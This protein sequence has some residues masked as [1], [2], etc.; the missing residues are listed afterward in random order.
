MSG[1]IKMKSI[2]TLLL[3]VLA[4]STF[5]NTFVVQGRLVDDIVLDGPIRKMIFNSFY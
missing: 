3:L 2:A 1:E 5:A 4:S